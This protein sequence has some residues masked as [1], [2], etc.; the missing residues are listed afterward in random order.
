MSLSYL[1]SFQN[2]KDTSKSDLNKPSSISR[3]SQF[4]Y[5]KQTSSWKVLSYDIY[6]LVCFHQTNERGYIS[7]TCEDVGV[8]T[9]T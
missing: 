4:V 8:T 2:D 3:K 5:N 1:E 6:A 9:V 7:F